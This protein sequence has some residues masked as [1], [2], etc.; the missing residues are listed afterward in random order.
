MR[1]ALWLGRKSPTRRPANP[2]T[3]HGY[4]YLLRRVPVEFRAVDKRAVVGISTG[5]RVDDDPDGREATTAVEALDVALTSYWHDLKAGKDVAAIIRYR[6]AQL[7]CQQLG[8]QYHPLLQVAALP[9]RELAARLELLQSARLF[10]RREDVIALMGGVPEAR[11]ALAELPV[12]EMVNEVEAIS[13]ASLAGKS[14][15]QRRRWRN[16]RIRAASSLME[17]IG[18]DKPVNA[19]TRQDVLAMRQH[20]RDRILRGHVQIRSANKVIGTVASMY[21]TISDHFQFDLPWVFGHVLIRG[22]EAGKRAAFSPSF[23]QEYLL[24]EGV[25]DRLNSEARRILYL[26]VET[27]LRPSEACNLTRSTIILDHDVPHILVR[28]EGRQLKTMSSRRNIPLVGVALMAMRYQPDGFPRYR[29]KSDTLSATLNKALISRNLRASDGTQ[30]VYSVRHSFSDR[31]RNVKAPD[32]VVDYFMGHAGRGPKYG[33][34]LT[35]ENKR[36]WLAQIAFRPP[37]KV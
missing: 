3:I 36:E 27:G 26:M 1:A 6:K 5:I 20:W 35:L 12:S 37:Q 10:H 18:C 2:V 4:W 13:A 29:D 17:A 7:L 33:E 9:L 11:C 8:F 34:G 23:I 28:P 22:G 31:L 24:A 16:E 21:R 14:P 19:L 30:T 25:F 15:T 32:S